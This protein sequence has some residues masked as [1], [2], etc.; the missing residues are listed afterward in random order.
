MYLEPRRLSQQEIA[1]HLPPLRQP[2]SATWPVV[3]RWGGGALKETTE[4]FTPAGN[5][6]QSQAG[7]QVQPEAEVSP[8]ALGHTSREMEV[9]RRLSSNSTFD[10]P[11]SK[12]RSSHAYSIS[13]PFQNLPSQAFSPQSTL[14]PLHH[15][16]LIQKLDFRQYRLRINN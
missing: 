1:G 14:K 15:P 11:L 12:P 8:R 9:S 3:S 4:G 13:V 6:S 5:I 16:L 2:S 7:T 10:Y